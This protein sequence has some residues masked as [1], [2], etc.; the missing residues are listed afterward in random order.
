MALVGELATRSEDF[1]TWWGGHTVRIHT[2]GTKR[3]NHPVIGEL[4]L[5]YETLALPSNPGLSMATYLP[6][7]G[8]ASADA[9]DMLRSWIAEPNAAPSI[10]DF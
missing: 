5:G 9:L 4:T 6:E 1:R 3:N 10:R 7:P 8:S 2:S